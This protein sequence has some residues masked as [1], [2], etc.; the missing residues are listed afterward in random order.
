MAYHIWILPDG[1]ENVC[2]DVGVLSLNAHTGGLALELM[3]ISR[4]PKWGGC[5][6]VKKYDCKQTFSILTKCKRTFTAWTTQV[7]W[8]R[9]ETGRFSNVATL[10]G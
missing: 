1:F 8:S 2:E 4:G 10:S 5:I 3:K 9:F 6:W 7:V